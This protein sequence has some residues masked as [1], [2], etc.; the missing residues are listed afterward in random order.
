MKTEVLWL[1]CSDGYVMVSQDLQAGVMDGI[2][3]PLQT[4]LLMVQRELPL[5]QKQLEDAVKACDN[6]AGVRHYGCIQLTALL[7]GRRN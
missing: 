4:K 1:S 6:V 2:F 7:N 5:A 3:A